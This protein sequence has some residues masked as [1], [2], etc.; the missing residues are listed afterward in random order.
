[1]GNMTN[2]RTP[3][4]IISPDGESST[5]RYPSRRVV[6]W[7]RNGLLVIERWY[8]IEHAGPFDD[9]TEAVRVLEAAYDDGE[10][11]A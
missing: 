3:E 2:D 8:R 11:V 1:M 4:R 6:G 9:W 7:R 10:R 5:T